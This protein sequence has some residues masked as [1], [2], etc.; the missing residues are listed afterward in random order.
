LIFDEATSSLDHEAESVITACWDAL[1]ADRTILVIAHRLSTILHSDKVAVI[2][3]GRIVGF[4]HH[5][6]L[7]ETCSEY[8]ELFKEQYS[9]NA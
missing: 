1:C 9:H 2:A 3:E 6:N 5:R 4:D 7:L 8:M